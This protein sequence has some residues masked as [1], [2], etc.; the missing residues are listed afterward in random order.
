[1]SYKLVMLG[2]LASIPAVA[3]DGWD[4]GDELEARQWRT[5]TLSWAQ[6]IHP[7]PPP[8]AAHMEADVIPPPREM[9]CVDSLNW[10]QYCEAWEY[11]MEQWLHHYLDIHYSDPLPTDLPKFPKECPSLCDKW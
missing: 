11:S 3:G 5:P 7:S 9:W 10:E 1:M 4:L 8:S 2:L 6:S